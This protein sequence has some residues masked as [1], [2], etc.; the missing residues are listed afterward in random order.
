MPNIQTKD[1]KRLLGII[2]KAVNNGKPLTYSGAASEMNRTPPQDHA[3]TV[4]QMC[5]LLD[6][7]ACWAGVPLLALVAVRAKSGEINPK[8][9]KNPL[10]DAI[11]KRSQGYTFG[12]RDFAA[13]RSAIDDLGDRGNRKAWQ[14]VQDFYPGD[15]FFRRLRGEHTI[16]E[17][18]AIDDLGID[19]PAR[20]LSK[21]WRY[22][23]D[24]KVRAT[25]LARAKGRC[26]FCGAQG[27]L[28][29]DGT[30]YLETHHIIALADDG[31]DRVTNVIALCP[32]N[33]RE[34]HLGKQQEVLEKQM[35]EKLG[36]IIVAATSAVAWDRT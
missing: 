19:S 9:W 36:T 11:I 32:N 27:F 26:E 12:K 22:P 4:A 30:R 5:D 17:P 6:A 29:R 34:A 1:A 21:S 31:A 28:K 3:R 33:H 25:V 8:A 2:A 16:P 24:P 7:A 14:Y 35:I 23:R 15:R 18:D 10:R 20:E 13:I